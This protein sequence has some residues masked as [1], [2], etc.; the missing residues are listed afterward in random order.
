[1]PGFYLEDPERRITASQTNGSF[2]ALVKVV[3]G[4][5][6]A[7]IELSPTPSASIDAMLCVIGDD[8]AREGVAY[9][10]FEDIRRV[11]P[12]LP[13]RNGGE[14]GQGSLSLAIDWLTAAKSGGGRAH[15]L[16]LWRQKAALLTST[17][18]LSLAYSQ[19]IW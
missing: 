12:I 17:H 13:A 2:G 14:K 4:A 16:V 19:L 7:Q 8:F 6:P 11:C 5:C 15:P 10:K 3:C 9:I 1:M 18:L